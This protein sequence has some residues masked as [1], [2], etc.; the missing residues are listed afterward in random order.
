MGRRQ[1]LAGFTLL[2]LV[3]TL[4]VLALAVGLTLPSIARS[5]DTIRARA[6]VAR[7]SALLRH[8]RD[9]AITTQRTHTMV[10]DP[11][12]HRVTVVAGADEVVE[13]RV[14]AADLRVEANPPPQLSVRF[15]PYG[16]STGGDFRVTSGTTRYRVLV[17]PLTGR[18]RATRE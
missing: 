12:G 4:L 9:Q 11:V 13:T 1:D 10:V 18:V 3:I 17:D 6:E 5:T 16:V 8:T 14:L 7:F 15:E 2:E